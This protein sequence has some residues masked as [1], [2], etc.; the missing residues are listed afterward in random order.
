[1]LSFLAKEES[2]LSIK[3][4]MCRKEFKQHVSQP[5]EIRISPFD[6]PFLIIGDN[7]KSPKTGLTHSKKS[8]NTFSLRSLLIK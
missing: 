1:M 5:Y 2:M 7:L 4:N 8:S 6:S 3:Y